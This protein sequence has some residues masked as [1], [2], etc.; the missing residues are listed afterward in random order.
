MHKAGCC[1]ITFGVKAGSQK[2]IDSI[3]KRITLEQARNAVS[4]TIDLGMEVRCFFMFPHPEDT[5]ETIR[6]QIQFMKE[7]IDMGATENLA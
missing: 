2:I 5:E 4:T 7:L 1:F 3:G 6:E